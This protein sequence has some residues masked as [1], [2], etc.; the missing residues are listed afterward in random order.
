MK[1]NKSKRVE[2]SSKEVRINL[3]RFQEDMKNAYDRLKKIVPEAVSNK[4][5]RPYGKFSHII[6]PKKYAHKKATVII[7]K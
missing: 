3:E 1:K 5:I 2:I 7:K 6:L 4:E